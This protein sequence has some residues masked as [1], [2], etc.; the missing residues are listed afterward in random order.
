MTTTPSET[1]R[2]QKNIQLMILYTKVRQNNYCLR[3]YTHVNYDL[4]IQKIWAGEMAQGLKART[5]LPEE[6]SSIPSTSDGSELPIT[7]ALEG[8]NT[9]SLC[10]HLHSRA[11][12][13]TSTHT[14]THTQK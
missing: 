9:S 12:L 1:G 13:H 11:C 4:K 14:Y 3:I 6:Q 10:G 5:A 2:L 7:P 8:P